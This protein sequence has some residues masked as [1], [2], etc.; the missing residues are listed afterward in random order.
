VSD[1]TIQHN[2]VFDPGL[3][4]IRLVGGNSGLVDG[5]LVTGTGEAGI[6]LERATNVAV[7]GNY[8]RQVGTAGIVTG[9]S[10]P[11]AGHDIADNYVAAN[12]QQS[13]ESFPALLVRDSGVR[14]R[15]NTIRQN[16]GPAIAEPDGVQG[17]VYQDNWA[18]G[19][20]PWRIASAASRIRNHVPPTD[21]HR[22]V[23]AGSGNDAVRVEF[24]RAYARRPTLSFGR[25]GGAVREISFETDRNGNYVGAKISVG[26]EGATFDV[27][28]DEL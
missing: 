1:V 12:N 23:S 21:V 6:R 25:V 17:N 7:R 13:D 15:G 16:G 9:G 28:V 2:G 20:D 27:S 3:S 11:N 26:R 19:D 8:V 22:G 14:V 5:N 10:K 18:D 4:G 24:D